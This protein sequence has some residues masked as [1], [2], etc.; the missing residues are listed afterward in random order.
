[1][2]IKDKVDGKANVIITSNFKMGTI[3]RLNTNLK[4]T[5]GEYGER[6]LLNGANEAQASKK[7]KFIKEA[8]LI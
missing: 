8:N 7:E 4:E 1:M 3:D 5:R 2:T 6:H